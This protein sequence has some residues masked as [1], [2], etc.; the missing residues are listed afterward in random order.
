MDFELSE[1]QQVIADLAGR[2]F[3]DLATHERVREVERAGGFDGGLWAA[4]ADADLLALCLPESWGGGGFGVTELAIIAEAQGR[5]VAPVPLV[6]TLATAIVLAELGD[7]AIRDA[8]AEPLRTGSTVLTAALATPGANDGRS[9]PVHA[10]AERNSVLHLTGTAPVV[11]FARQAKWLLVPAT[12]DDGSL[13]AALIAT[14]QAGVEFVDLD[15]TGHQPSADVVLDVDVEVAWTLPA[16][17]LVRLRHVVLAANSSLVAGVADGALRMTA[18][19]VSTRLQFGRPLASFQA[20]RQRAADAYIT[21]QAMQTTALRAAWRLDAGLDA[22]RDVEIA[23]F[24]A[25]E[26]GQSVTQACQ[27]LHGGVG[28][29]VEYPVHRYFLWAIQIANELGSASAHLGEVGRSLAT[30]G[31]R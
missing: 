10:T 26:G 4:L 25:A 19:Y 18:E 7:D 11:P 17:A 28:A 16:A 8:L 31:T 14:D 23:A 9:A 21:V 20:V 13:L 5:R 12:D 27:H 2:L 29:D 22:A 30:G 24:W 15:T 6:P 3:D 1:E